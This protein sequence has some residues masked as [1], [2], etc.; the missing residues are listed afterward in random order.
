MATLYS[1]STP[2]LI[3]NIVLIKVCRYV[4]QAW[5]DPNNIIEE[6]KAEEAASETKQ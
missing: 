2:A 5:K 1:P 4:T 6:I 3:S